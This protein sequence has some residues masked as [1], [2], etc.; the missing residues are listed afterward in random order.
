MWR[1]VIALVLLSCVIVLSGPG[2]RAQM[3]PVSDLTGQVGLGLLLRQLA[4][5]GVLMQADRASRRREQRAAGDARM[6][7]GRTHRRRHGDARQRRPERDRPGDVRGARR[8]AHRGA[9]RRAPLDGAEQYFTRAVD[10]GYSFSIDETFEKW[11]REEIL[12]DYVRLIRTIRPD[13]IVAMRPDGTGG[14]QHHQAS[15]DHSRAR[16]SSRPAIRRSSPSRSR[17][18]CGRGSRRSSTSPGRFGFPGEPPPPPGVTLTDGESR[19]LRPAARQ[20]L[21]R[22]RQPER[23]A[24]TSARAWRSCSRCRARRARATSSSRCAMPGQKEKDERRSST[25][26]TRPSRASRATCPAEAPAGAH[27]GLAAIADA[28]HGRHEQLRGRRA[29]RAVAPLVAGLQAVRA[30][31]AQ[32]ASGAMGDS[33]TTRATR[34]TR[35]S[36]QGA[37]VRRRGARRGRRPARSAGRRRRRGAGPAGEADADGRQSRQRA[38]IAVKEI[39]FRGLD[40]DA[41]VCTSR[42]GGARRRLHGARRRCEISKQA[43][44]TRASTGRGCPTPRAT[45]ST[46]TRRSACRSGRRRSA[47]QFALEIGGATIVVGARRAVPLRGQHLQRREAD[48]AAR[49]AALLGGADARAS[50]SS[51]RG[52]DRHPR[53]RR[54]ARDARDRDQRQ[55]GTARAA[56]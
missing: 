7:P 22:D 2:A 14:G 25:A 11:G 24:C 51:R 53:A 6:G 27:A 48:G 28:R 26:S 41:G 45:R 52:R 1:R 46:P 36:A 34:S 18:A 3:P 12:G 9:A 20:D 47:R 40:G 29:A 31:R 30:L 21:R 4:T 50:R 55:H 33:R 8:A 56:T 39:G 13:V 42:S 43:R 17:R 32:L 35:G 23:A 37:A 15:A 54:R 16:R 44:L 10:F 38:P 49:G 19:R 5:T